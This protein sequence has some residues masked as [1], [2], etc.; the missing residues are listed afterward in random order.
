MHIQNS[1][2]VFRR[3]TRVHCVV[4]VVSAKRVDDPLGRDGEIVH[5]KV[6]TVKQVLRLLLIYDVVESMMG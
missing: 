1:S 5:V 6:R 2:P 4:R 3:I